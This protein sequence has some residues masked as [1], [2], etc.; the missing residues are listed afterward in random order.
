MRIKVGYLDAG[1]W[2]ITMSMVFSS[3]T[4]DAIETS[5]SKSTLI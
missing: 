3:D 5:V 4:R 1:L 2:K